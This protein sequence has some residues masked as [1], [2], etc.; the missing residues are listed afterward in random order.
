MSVSTIISKARENARHHGWPAAIQILTVYLL[1]KFIRFERVFLMAFDEPPPHLSMPSP[2]RARLATAE[3]V[4]RIA[5]DATFDMSELSAARIDELYAMGHRCVFNVVGE[6]VA[7]YSWMTT[8]EVKIPKLG[9]LLEVKPREGYT[10]KGMTHPKFRGMKVGH[11]RYLFWL[12]Y[13]KKNGRSVLLCDFAF[14]NKATL[15][16]VSKLNLKKTG[17]A[18]LVAAGPFRK[19]FLTGDFLGRKISRL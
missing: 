7:G 16:R 5:E 13:L 15:T 4:K 19:L 9:I 8:A 10:Y 12:D 6:A 3:E 14:D 11:D 17:T 18:T 1:R 2:E